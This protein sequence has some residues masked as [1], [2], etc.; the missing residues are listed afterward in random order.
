MPCDVSGAREY[1]QKRRER[2]K[3]KK[4][5][6]TG[7]DI[8]LL[9]TWISHRRRERKKKREGRIRSRTPGARAS[10]G[11]REGKVY[12][13]LT[14]PRVTGIFILADQLFDLAPP[15]CLKGRR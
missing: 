11:R 9:I 10:A 7:I 4:E 2:R 3:K 8:S 15:E 13:Q 5:T 14:A 1:L 12:D 6:A